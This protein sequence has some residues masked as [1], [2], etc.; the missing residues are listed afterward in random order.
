MPP[1]KLQGQRPEP[2]LALYIHLPWCISK[3]PYCD[4]NSHALAADLPE[5]AY[6]KALLQDIESALPALGDRKF[7][8]IFF[9]GG[10]PS[11]F[12]PESIAGLID[13]VSAS[14]RL[15]ANAEISLEANPGAADMGRFRGYRQAGV[16][17]LSIGVQS[18]QDSLLKQLGRA[19]DS[20]AARQAV[21]MAEECFDRYSLDLM[22]ALPGQSIIQ[23]EAD[24]AQAIASGAD[25]LSCYQLTIEPNTR[26]FSAPP[27]LPGDD[28]AEAIEAA[29]HSALACA[30]YA[31]YE[32]SNWARGDDQCRHNLNYWR[33]GD[34]LG[35][36]AGAHSKLT[37]DG[38]IWRQARVR[39]PASYQR[40]VAHGEHIAEQRSI[41]KQAR[42][43]EFMLNALRLEQGFNFQLF[44]DRTGLP[45]ETL[46]R[47][48]RSAEQ[49]G[50]LCWDNQGVRASV[51]GRR[52][53]NAIIREFLPDDG[54]GE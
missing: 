14:G 15:A 12:T 54:L 21:A 16:N 39:T 20:H 34:Y 11:L 49:A 22:Y 24:V 52:Y 37:I 4:F 1:V 13:R 46:S 44:E 47:G 33:Y 18:F 50:L 9:G 41:G 53:L 35:I 42:I 38:E 19:H 26:F 45:R 36:G 23:A 3:C 27:R 2:P 31:A 25:H 30:G 10:T 8:S 5:Q 43:F 29:V 28:Q 51:R 6:L 7:S 40:R 32:V 17:R 48:L